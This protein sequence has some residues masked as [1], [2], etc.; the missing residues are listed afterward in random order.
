[1]Q[2]STS[3]DAP[4]NIGVVMLGRKRPGFDQEWNKVVYQQSL[5][6]LEDLGFT[7]V[8]ADNPVVDDETLHVTLQKIHPAKCEA[9]VVL[10]P[11]IGNGQLAL[12]IS[13][14][15]ADPVV[16]WATPER[17]TDGKVSSC[18]LVGQHLWASV[19]RQAGHP[20]EFVYGDSADAAV[21]ADLIR[22][23]ALCRTFGRLRHAKVGVI[24]THV[25]GFI[26]LA[27]DPFLLRRAIG[28]Q[29]HPLSLPQYI[30]RVR[31]VAEDAVEKD[32]QQVRALGLRPVNVTDDALDINSRCYLAMLDIMQ[33]ESLDALALQCWPEIPN[34]LGQWPYLAISRL[35]S[36][37]H[38]VSIEGDVD[39]SIGSLMS[40]SLGLG[41]GFLTDW[42]EHDTS[43]IFFWHPGMAPLDMCH[44]I[45]S[46]DGPTLGSHFNIVKPY[47]VDGQLRPG[48][49]VTVT[50]LWRCD[51]ECHMTAFEGR[52]IPPRRKIT[53]NSI[54][55]EVADR[56]VPRRFDALIHAG[57][58]HH[59]SLL[60]GEY[61][62]TFRRLARLL[63]IHWHD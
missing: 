13:Q 30:D 19:L 36:A 62:E 3:Q 23:I 46:E 10:Q 56:N 17:P 51:N 52:S 58:P 24:G 2:K 44:A 27:A 47:V 25:P 38:A 57:M 43:T 32:I 54:L 28:I 63:Q 45:G 42:L 49:P 55:V 6:A 41:P 50:R 11:S 5:A 22:A 61:A 18:S 31:A 20:F 7:C 12:T 60:F 21:R 59:V 9:L 8:G 35:S 34:M 26:D 39:G 4:R 15:W 33:E 37:G 14:H 29:L 16:L 1:M 40:S 53:G 48:Q